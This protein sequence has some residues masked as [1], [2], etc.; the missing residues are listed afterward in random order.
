MK[1]QMMK[2]MKLKNTDNWAKMM[3]PVLDAYNNSPHTAIKIEP[4]KMNKIIK[5]KY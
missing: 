4:N 1:N 5:F 2:C 3:G